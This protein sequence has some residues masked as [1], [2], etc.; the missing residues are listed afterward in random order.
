MLKKSQKTKSPSKNKTLKR[1]SSIKFALALIVSV[2]LATTSVIA[3]VNVLILLAMTG[4]VGIGSW[5]ESE[6]S[7]ATA[8]WNQHN[9]DGDYFD[10]ST[11]NSVQDANDIAS[12]YANQGYEVV[13]WGHGT[14]STSIGVNGQSVDESQFD[15]N[16]IGNTFYCYKHDGI[17]SYTTD[18]MWQEMMNYFGE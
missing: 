10:Y 18:E 6:V 12:S 17:S 7:A 9:I 4:D 11:F 5:S 16:Y 15:S 2:V 8:D 13:V 14:G 3:G 1:L